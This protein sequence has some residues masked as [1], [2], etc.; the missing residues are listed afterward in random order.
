MSGPLLLPTWE[1]L[2]AQAP[3]MVASMRRYLEQIA[4]SL[5]PGSVG[6][7]DL[8]LRCFATFLTQQAPEVASVADV[9][10]THI[11]DY[12]PWLAARPGQKVP[13]LKPSTIA[14]HLGRLRMFF[15]RIQEWDW[16][17][18]PSKVPIVNG[19]LPRQDHP[20]PK[21]L[22]DAAAAKFLRRSPGP[23]PNAGPGGV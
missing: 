18:A 23:P 12:K 19:D 11:E 16:D 14:G 2:E 13:R 20:L 8:A 3:V 10:R 1:Q 9:T 5:Q 15:I 7:A 17:H 21:A 6:G 4:C 22:D